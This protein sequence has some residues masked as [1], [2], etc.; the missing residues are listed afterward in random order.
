MTPWDSL[1][2]GMARARR[3][4]ATRYGVRVWKQLGSG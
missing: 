4:I 1:R 3:P 2:V